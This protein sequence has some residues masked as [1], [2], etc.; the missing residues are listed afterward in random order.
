MNGKEISDGVFYGIIR[1]LWVVFI[2]VGI[3]TV[4]GEYVGGKDV[5]YSQDIQ[6]AHAGRHCANE[7]LG[8]LEYE[9]QRAGLL[10][11]GTLEQV[12]VCKRPFL[13]P[14]MKWVG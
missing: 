8:H 11:L 9:Y 13:W 6:G 4:A 1:V 3:A 10:G 14:I 5:V 7:Y 12:L 2:V